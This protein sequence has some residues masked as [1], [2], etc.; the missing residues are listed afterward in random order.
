MLFFIEFQG[1]ILLLH[2]LGHLE[3]ALVLET[4][5]YNQGSRLTAYEL[6][7]QGVPFKLIPDSAVKHKS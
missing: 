3:L 5:P 7:Q 4:R 6:Q 1:A 2:R